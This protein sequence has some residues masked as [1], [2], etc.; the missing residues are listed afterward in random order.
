[1]LLPHWKK[2]PALFWGSLGAMIPDLE[3]SIQPFGKRIFPTHSGRLTHGELVN[4]WHGGFT[5]FCIEG[6]AL[7][8]LNHEIPRR[9][10]GSPVLKFGWTLSNWDIPG[11]TNENGAEYKNL[12]NKSLIRNINL[13]MD[14]HKNIAVETSWGVWM[15]EASTLTD[16]DTP[17][18]IVIQS[19][20]LGITLHT[21]RN[22]LID[23]F[24]TAGTGVYIASKSE[25]VN[26]NGIAF[27]RYK[28]SNFGFHYGAGIKIPVSSHGSI[29][30]NHCYHKI[31]FNKKIDGYREYSGWA[32]GLTLERNL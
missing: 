4:F 19:H 22:K 14:L 13:A 1:L 16:R 15:K 31:S 9:E 17:E 11:A 10:D 21:H 7:Y 28:D 3:H 18:K 23:P 25:A 27:A 30:I 2:D 6:L 29:I 20:L 26:R 12:N 5:N 8:A 24:I 32:G